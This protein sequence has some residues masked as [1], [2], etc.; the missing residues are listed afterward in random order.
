[1]DI[2]DHLSIGWH[3]FCREMLVIASAARSGLIDACLM[4]I[5]SVLTFG[6]FLPEMGMPC[7]YSV[8][9]FIG[10]LLILVLF[11]GYHTG[12]SLATDLVSK[13]I[14]FYHAAL[15]VRLWIVLL[16]KI[17]AFALR[18]VVFVVPAGCLGIVLIHDTSAVAVHPVGIIAIAALISIFFAQLF[19]SAVLYFTPNRFYADLWPCILAPMYSFGCI[20]F[21]W[22]S[23]YLLRPYI[24]NAML[25]NPMTYCTE[26]LRAALLAG[27]DTL[28]LMTCIVMLFLFLHAQFC[29]LLDVC[30][31]SS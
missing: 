9:L 7:E 14:L 13:K 10:S 8:P 27:T 31:T 17:I 22:K 26:G 16:V 2:S 20:S 1:M 3:L 25:I 23:V 28:S 4:S 21:T 5:V 29:F 15:P 11:F 12:A 18:I 24:A 6:Y 30:I 19:Y